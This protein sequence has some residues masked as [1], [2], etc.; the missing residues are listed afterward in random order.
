MEVSETLSQINQI[1]SKSE[2][3]FLQLGNLFPS[4]LNR[5]SGTSL[6]TLGRMFSSLSESDSNSKGK[7]KV[8]FTDYAAKYDPLFNQLNEKIEDLG[9]L[10]KMIAEIKEDSEQMELI[11]LNAMVISIKS[12]EKGQAFSRITENLQRLSNDMNLFAGKLSEEEAQLLAHINTL[13]DIFSGI[14]DAQKNL[15]VKGSSGSA[16]VKNLIGYVSEPI[17]SMEIAINSIYPPIQKAMEGLQLQDMI[18]QA[19]DHVQKCVQEAGKSSNVVPGSDEELDYVSFNIALYQLCEEVLKDINGYITQSFNTF[20]KNWAKVIDTLDSVET[21]KNN[22][23]SRFL[24]EYSVGN[25]NIEKRLNGI[26]ENFQ[27]MMGEFNT[28]HLVQKDL[29]HTCQNITERARIIYAV[30][31]N[32]RPVMSRLHHVRILQQIEVAKNDA[33][34]SVQDSVTDMDNLI[35]SAN[36]SLDAMQALL[37]SFIAD[38]GSMLSTFT[39]SISKDNENMVSLRKEKNVFFDELKKGQSELSSIIQNF[40][41]FPDGFQQKCVTVQQNLQDLKRIGSQLEEFIEAMKQSE[42]NLLQKK[43]A[44]MSEKGLSNWQIKNNKFSELINQFTITAHKEAAGK[45]GGFAIEKGADS[46]DVT[47]F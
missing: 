2:Q 40:T 27:S 47:F 43:S 31:D 35:S 44:L 28:Y 10:D 12:G 1:S 41:V 36:K 23:E 6:Q 13:K 30:F 20:D 21:Q 9:K 37:E 19:L 14:L 16:D 24:S 4:L 29:L 45:I 15:S 18:R 42:Q 46:G 17:S 11:A 5:D 3:I 32:L 26:V 33:I 8:L 34:K 38:T 22:F 7:E 39:V 25:E